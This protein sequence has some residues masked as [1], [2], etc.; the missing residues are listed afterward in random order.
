M[1]NL[2]SRRLCFV[3]AP[4]GNDGSDIRLRSDQIFN[5]VIAP[6]AS[7]CG[8]DSVRA[9]KISQPG[10]ITSQIIQHLVDDPLVVADLTGRNANVFYEL[11]I[12]HVVRKPVVQLI[13]LG[14]SIPF[15]VA[16]TRTIQ[17]D[18]HDLDSVAKCRAE[19]ERQIR[20]HEADPA[21]V[22]TPVSVAIDLQAMRQSGN[23]LEKNTAQII[24]ILN[25][26][27]T[28]VSELV[29][30][31]SPVPGGAITLNVSPDIQD[32]LAARK[33]TPTLS[34]K[35]GKTLRAFRERLKMT[36]R[37]VEEASLEIADAQR[38]SEYV[39]STAR[40]SQIENDGALPSI[41]KLTALAKIYKISVAEMLNTYGIQP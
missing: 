4:I 22:D 23:L 28:G 10:M 31:K 40:L 39:I 34:S 15:D 3:I 2:S 13:Q 16:Q 6:A 37:M 8:Y 27:S 12:R 41:Y 14:E 36:P 24:S 30:T 18:H 21:H 26:L 7:E 35:A 11:A 32:L 17:V 29:G 33:T 19:M 25:E 20:W 1:S 38:S 5:H 9:D